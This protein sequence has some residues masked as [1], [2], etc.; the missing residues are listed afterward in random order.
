MSVASQAWFL[1]VAQK[2]LPFVLRRVQ[3]FRQDYA[4]LRAQFEK[5][6]NEVGRLPTASARPGGDVS[7]E[8]C[9]K[10]LRTFFWGFIVNNA[11]VTNGT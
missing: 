8:R 3:K 9:S 10:P 5:V 11:L 4:E 6:K 2:R 1:A 7:A